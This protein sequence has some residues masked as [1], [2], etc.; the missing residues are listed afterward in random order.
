MS[1]RKNAD[2]IESSDVTFRDQGE[3]RSWL[4]E[5]ADLSEGIWLR[6]AKK[7][8]GEQSITYAQALDEALC[9]GWIDGQKKP[10]DQ[11]SWLQRFCPRRP[12]SNWSKI[13]IQHAERLTK[14]GRMTP[15]GLEE[16]E[17]AK[18]DGRWATAYDSPK[19]AEPPDD[20]LQELAKDPSALA[21]FKT[22]NRANVYAIVYRLQ[23]A[24][25]PETREKRMKLILEMMAD[26]KKFH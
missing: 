10:C 21:F 24:K 8:S 12:R 17:A 3:F 16:I 7:D 14:E 26:G 23:T 6:F 5:N 15:R 2:P 22:L 25:R 20:F 1:E 13:N 18:G 9:F 4:S 11:I 19:D